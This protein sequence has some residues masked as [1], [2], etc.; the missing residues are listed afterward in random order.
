[1]ANVPQRCFQFVATV[2]EAR[3]KNPKSHYSPLTHN[4]T[5]AYARHSISP[6]KCL[7]CGF[8]LTVVDGQLAA[9][10]L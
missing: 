3:R 6:P 4:L 7:L 8:P 1:M 5:T 9:V 10:K 2:G